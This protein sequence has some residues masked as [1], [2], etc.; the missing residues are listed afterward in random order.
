M[1]F[2]FTEN[3]QNQELAKSYLDAGMQHFINNGA[4]EEVTAI[5]TTLRNAGNGMGGVL[6]LTPLRTGLTPDLNV[7]INGL[8]VWASTP[9]QYL[10]IAENEPLKGMRMQGFGELDTETFDGDLLYKEMPHE[11]F[12]KIYFKDHVTGKMLY[13][14]MGIVDKVKNVIHITEIYARFIEATL[15]AIQH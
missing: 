8:S 14:P 1:S 6:E 15:K 11:Y 2:T 12:V 5:F 7:F 9:E 4:N 13:I 10:A 3:K